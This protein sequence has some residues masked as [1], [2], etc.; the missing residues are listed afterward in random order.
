VE[1]QRC[2]VSKHEGNFFRR[3]QERNRTSAVKVRRSLM[4]DAVDY[5]HAYATRAICRAR[6][7]PVGKL[8]RIQRAVGRI[9]LLLTKEAALAP[10]VDY[11]ERGAPTGKV[12]CSRER[13]S[14][15]SA[16]DA[17]KLCLAIRIESRAPRDTKCFGTIPDSAGSILRCN[18]FQDRPDFVHADGG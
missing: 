4:P 16:W 14:V 18:I 15:I 12:D 6:R 9:Y 13:A 2:F 7:M 5:L 3:T 11:L 1:R 10:S 17:E 8:K